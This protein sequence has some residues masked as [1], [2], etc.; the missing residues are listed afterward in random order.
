MLAAAHGVMV[1]R[2]NIKESEVRRVLEW[3]ANGR[4]LQDYFSSLAFLVSSSMT[5]FEAHLGYFD[6]L[7]LDV[8][9]VPLKLRK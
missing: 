2:L 6:E 8:T 9:F 5:V 3:A 4:L 1:K 7:L